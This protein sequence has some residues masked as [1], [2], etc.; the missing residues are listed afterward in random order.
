MLTFL[1]ANVAS[2]VASLLDYLVSIVLLS[3]FSA[4]AMV[5]GITGT[6]CG[7]ICNF[8]IG[9]N[10]VFDSAG[11]KVAGQVLR[12]FIV[13]TGN[14]VLAAM[15]LYILVRLLG[16]NFIFSKVSVS[17]LVAVCYNYP[18]QKR[19]VFKNNRRL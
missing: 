18:L 1:K 3:Y 17:L 16:A 4:D 12:Y 19:Y 7:G 5:A 10:W 11:N 6:I 9:R 15:G 8:L 14:L 13:W 2:V